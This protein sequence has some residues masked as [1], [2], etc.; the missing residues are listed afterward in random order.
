MIK[1][2]ADNSLREVI[3]MANADRVSKDQIISIMFTCGQ[4]QL[5]YY[6]KEA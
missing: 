1:V 2:I 5:I 4:Y 3:E 6:G